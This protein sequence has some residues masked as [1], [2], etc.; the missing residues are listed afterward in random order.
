MQLFFKRLSM[1]RIPIYQPCLAGKEK[2]YV[3][4]CLNSTWISSKGTFISAFEKS[5][6]E[7]TESRFAVSVCNG[8]VAL[9]LVLAA[10]GIGPGDEVIVPSFTYV[11]S[12]NCIRHV[13]AIPVF[14]DSLTKTW[15]IDPA[16][17]CKKI[18]PKTKAIIVVHLYGYP[19]DMGTL[20]RIAKEKGLFLIEDCAEAFGTR[21]H[22]THVGTFGD[23]STFSFFGNK[24]ITTGEGGMI[25]TNSPSLYEKMVHLRG[26]GVCKEKT[27]WHTEIGYNFRMTNICA[28]IGLAQLER[29]EELLLKKRRI[30]EAYQK[31]LA[32][33]PLIILGEEEGIV[34]SFWMISLLLPHAHQRDLLRDFLDAHGI[35]TRPFF[36]PVHTMPMYVQEGFS[37]PIA[38][39]ISSRGLNLPSY[40]DLSLEQIQYITGKI[41]E[42]FPLWSS[43]SDAA[44]MPEALP[45]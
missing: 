42:F 18:S 33:L 11:A 8:T 39:D 41:E 17:A 6:A 9:H 10:L 38:E 34:N 20:S 5:F 26:Q 25:V 30:A 21:Y 3:L 29:A 31:A 27:Y 37:L 1:D 32:N 23:A 14:V 35:E 28:A 19:C 15:Q 12:V 24:T 16:D 44:D 7:Y 40:P 4:E 13:G 22:G 36:Y 45:I 2:E 43:S